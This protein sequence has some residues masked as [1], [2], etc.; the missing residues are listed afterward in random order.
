MLAAIPS[1][2]YGMWGLFVFVPVF[3]QYVQPFL[4]ALGNVPIIGGMF[5]GRR[6]A[7]AFHRGPDPVDHDHP[8]HRGGDARRVRAGAD[9]VEGIGLRPGSTTWEVMWRVV[10][11]FTKSGVIGGIMLGLGR[12]L[13]ETMAV[14]FVIGN[15]FKWSGSLFSQLHRL[16]AGQRIQ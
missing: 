9:H 2:I 7:S 10:L 3:Q 1:I 5:A 11:P 13:G 14:T 12:A 15:A 16:G 6:S 8:L 4:I